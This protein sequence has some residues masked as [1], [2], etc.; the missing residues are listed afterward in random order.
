LP[1]I[2]YRNRAKKLLAT[3]SSRKDYPEL[4]ER[5]NYYNK[6]EEF[7]ALKNPVSVADFELEDVDQKV[8][9]FDAY[10]P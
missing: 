3:A 7:T 9:F 2:I 10:Q 1:N 5:V 8:Y 4:M 6:L